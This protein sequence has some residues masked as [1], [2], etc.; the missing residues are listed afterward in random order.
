MFQPTLNQFSVDQDIPILHFVFFKKT[1]YMKGSWK[2]N[3]WHI[4]HED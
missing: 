3:N 2:E 1:N 4:L